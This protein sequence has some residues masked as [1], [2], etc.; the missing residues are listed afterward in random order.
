MEQ[1][2]TIRPNE[3]L[4]PA[5]KYTFR[6]KVMELTE[7]DIANEAASGVNKF[8][9]GCTFPEWKMTRFANQNNFFD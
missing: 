1:W 9:D 6:Y 7:P 8:L 2:H 5:S 3:A 4:L